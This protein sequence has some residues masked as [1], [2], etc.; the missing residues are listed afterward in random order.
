VRIVTAHFDYP[1]EQQY[2]RCLC[3][4]R[5]S[6]KRN[7]PSSE[8][9]VLELRHPAAVKGAYQG[10]VNNHIKLLAYSQVKIDQPTAFIDVDTLVLRDLSQL[11]DRYS[12]DVAAARRPAPKEHLFNGG[13]VLFK[14]TARAREFMKKWIEI[15]ERM[16]RDQAFHMPWHKKYNGQ[17]QA[18]FGYLYETQRKAKIAELPTAMLN[19]CEQDWPTI[20]TVKPYVLHVRKRLMKAAMGIGSLANVSPRYR[21][22]VALWREYELCGR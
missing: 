7:A 19:A 1:G 11:F 12:F 5:A 13:V 17:N 6:V 2:A 18:S 8:L 16:L 22:G 20:S 21:P 15:D 9:V 4:L 3:A 14:P 10:W